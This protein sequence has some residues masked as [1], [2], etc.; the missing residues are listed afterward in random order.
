MNK[1]ESKE[2]YLAHISEDGRKQSIE[3]HCIETEAVCRQ[4]G[5]KIGLEK[6]SA[7]CGLLHDMGKATEIFQEYLLKLNDLKRGDVNHSSTGGKFVE[8]LK[9][10]GEP[11]SEIT[12]LLICEAIISHHN[13]GL[14]DIYTP[15]GIN[16]LNRRIN[17]KKEI[18]YDEALQ[19]FPIKFDNISK[20]FNCAVT[21]IKDIYE[22][23]I[24]S[25][26][27]DKAEL[28]FLLGLI[29]RYLYSCLIDADRYGTYL[30][31]INS[32]DNDK[33]IEGFWDI[34]SKSLESYIIKLD[35]S[36][37]INKERQKISDSCLL[38]SSNNNGI[39]QL[40]V[41]TGGGKTI[42]SMRYAINC[43]KKF[44]KDRIFYI[45]P[46]KT[47]LEQNADKIREI[48]GDDCNDILEHHSDFISSDEKYKLLTERWQSKIILTTM[49][50]FLDTL[51]A[52]KSSSARR[53]HSLANSVIIIDEVQSLPLKCIYMFNTTMNFLSEYCNCSIVL[54][55][56]TQPQLHKTKNHKIKLSQPSC[57]IEDLTNVFKSFKRT[58]IHDITNSSFSSETLSDFVI[59]KH[60]ENKRTLVIMNTKATAL[61]LYQKLKEK[62]PDTLICYLSTG[63]CPAHRKKI[64]DIISKADDVICI[65]TQMIEAGVDI[66]FSCVIRSLAGLDSIA[67]A[68]GRCNRNKEKDTGDVYVVRSSEENLERLPDI[69][70]GQKATI[71]VLE[72]FKLNPLRFNNDLLSVQAMESFYYYYYTAREQKNEMSY[73]LFKNRTGFYKDTNLYDLLSFNSIGRNQA[74]QNNEKLYFINQ[75]FE[76]AGRNFNS[77]DNEGIGVI[78]P[79]EN[80]LSLLHEAEKNKN[81]KDKVMLMRKLQ[82]FSINLFPY[83]KKLLDDENA[84]TLIEELGVFI[85]DKNYYDNEYGIKFKKTIMEVLIQ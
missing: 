78:V 47:I 38:F 68:A 76:S 37:A 5:S 27:N 56:A 40:H 64:I 77:I 44:N 33:N 82:S 43:A 32:D 50:Q 57:M 8:T 25:F 67:Q 85:V 10:E 3:E 16:V 35:H 84:L 66:S 45:A 14:L 80:C 58:M 9:T 48:F 63:L 4:F 61:N 18:F 36:S 54:C 81:I 34:L 79:Y 24:L 2:T 30:F 29:V 60:I 71:Y 21:E 72:A 28:T 6:T 1:S 7:L 22:R 13:N 31:E 65:S 73:L 69:K 53:F 74:K 75:A 17:P 62:D 70:E 39:F 49:V 42:S 15:D 20:E 51:F 26:G 83:E 55:T 11:F 52:G 19:N 41:P 46:Y 23:L 12:S 59:E